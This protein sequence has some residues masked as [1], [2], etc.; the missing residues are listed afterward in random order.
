MGLP[1]REIYFRMFSWITRQEGATRYFVAAKHL[2]EG[3]PEHGRTLPKASMDRSMDVQPTVVFH[4]GGTR[5]YT[6]LFPG[7]RG[8]TG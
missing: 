3:P 6:G 4:V 1:G 8:P 7:Q 2:N 5:L